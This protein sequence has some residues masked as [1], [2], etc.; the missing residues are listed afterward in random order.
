M[1]FMTKATIEKL[2]RKRKP[3][4]TELGRV[5]VSEVIHHSAENET[6]IQAERIAK[7]K[8]SLETQYDKEAFL[9][10]CS[11]ERWIYAANVYAVRAIDQIRE[12][13]FWLLRFLL[14]A[15]LIE[16]QNY[17]FYISP[18]AKAIVDQLN[19]DEK[20]LHFIAESDLALLATPQTEE[21]EAQSTERLEGI[22]HSLKKIEWGY[23]VVQSYNYAL[24]ALAE[25]FGLLEPTTAF[26]HI[27]KF[28]LTNNIKERLSILTG[29]L[30]INKVLAGKGTPEAEDIQ[31]KIDFVN[32]HITP[33]TKG[34]IDTFKST[35]EH[36]AKI[37]QLLKTLKTIKENNCGYI[38]EGHNCTDFLREFS[39]TG[40]Y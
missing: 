23:E 22:K 16:K 5:I 32:E 37:N 36:E 31:A 12:H 39:V 21:Q 17:L 3:T 40:A 13:Q 2:A 4:G 34:Y 38:I 29:T 10:Y 8:E 35:K 7:Q 28:D 14:D 9:S 15:I 26:L 6:Y 18:K 11:L 27:E 20:P 1:A 25:V 19:D 33:F 24:L 30:E